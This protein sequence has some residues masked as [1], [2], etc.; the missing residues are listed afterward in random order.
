MKLPA[1]LLSFV[2]QGLSRLPAVFQSRDPQDLPETE[3]PKE[4]RFWIVR[5]WRAWRKARW[6]KFANSPSRYWRDWTSWHAAR[7]AKYSKTRSVAYFCT[8][9]LFLIGPPLIASKYR[10]SQAKATAMEARAYARVAR[11]ALLQDC[12][13][14]KKKG[15][16]VPK[17]TV[18]W[19][20]CTQVEDQEKK[21]IALQ[22]EEAR[23]A[24][25]TLLESWE[26]FVLLVKWVLDTFLGVT[27]IVWWIG[28]IM[29]FTILLIGYVLLGAHTKEVHEAAA[30][31]EHSLTGELKAGHE[32]LFQIEQTLNEER[33]DNF[34]YV[35]VYRL[36]EGMLTPV[37]RLPYNP[38]FENAYD[39]EKRPQFAAL[40]EAAQKLMPE[41]EEWEPS[42][43]L[44]EQLP[45]W[46]FFLHLKHFLDWNE[47]LRMSVGWAAYNY[48]C[49]QGAAD[50]QSQFKFYQQFSAYVDRAESFTQLLLKKPPEFEGYDLIF[51]DAFDA[52]QMLSGIRRKMDERL[53]SLPGDEA[54]TALV[55]K[56]VADL[57]PDL[58]Q[59][60]RLASLHREGAPV[61]ESEGAVT[62]DE[63][64]E[65]EVAGQSEEE[66]HPAASE[67][68]RRLHMVHSNQN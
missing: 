11:Q 5:K 13:D 27:A 44:T 3:P 31:M 45:W 56:S 66:V 32:Q 64:G 38:D 20:S 19:K 2:E 28:G 61:S 30:K 68:P 67:H 54:A 17:M 46:Y 59:I 8:F 47:G 23:L 12:F 49:M 33:S 7:E 29:S 43:D 58:Q 15:D 37:L 4:S 52:K 63:G 62:P 48:V 55:Q 34:K 42:G 53:K 57:Q 1:N 9:L 24:N 10:S 35:A 36:L 21:E 16:L 39:D 40:V 50:R 22:Q 6:E 51:S 60:E 18:E 65:G 14:R 41:P 26:Q 25:Q